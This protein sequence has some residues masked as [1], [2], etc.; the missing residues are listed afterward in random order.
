MTIAPSGSVPGVP[1]GQFVDG[2]LDARRSRCRIPSIS[3]RRP[4]R[5][6]CLSRSNAAN[7]FARSRRQVS[8]A[9]DRR[10]APSPRRGKQLRP[11]GLAVRPV[12]AHR[13]RR[14]PLYSQL[15]MI[16]AFVVQRFL[17]RVFVSGSWMM[18][19]LPVN[20]PR[21]VDRMDV[22]EGSTRFCSGICAI[23]LVKPAS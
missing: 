7:S 11:A 10:P 8:R 5:G 3:G 22:A 13:L 2:S 20:S 16:H 1:R 23:F 6:R 12:A 15:Q 4:T 19:R 9:D 21:A 14:T 17:S 18:P